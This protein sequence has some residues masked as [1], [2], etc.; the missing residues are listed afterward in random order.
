MV[1]YSR[2]DLA[3]AFADGDK[4]ME[5]NKYDMLTVGGYGGRLVMTGE[6]ERGMAML[7]RASENSEI[8]AWQNFFMFLG[9]YLGGDMNA[10]RFDAEQITTNSFPF[11]LVARAITENDAG[12][13]DQ[14]RKAINSLIELQP[15]WRDN[16]RRMLEL[17]IYDPK[18]VTRLLRDLAAAGLRSGD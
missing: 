13:A 2:H 14:A 16:P 6:V 18:I 10:A 3:A 7:R 4:A 12:N 8:R 11:G 9:S 17:Q 5:L 1:L 15:Q